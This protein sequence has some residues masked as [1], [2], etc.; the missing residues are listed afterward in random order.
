MVRVVQEVPPEI[1]GEEKGERDRSGDGEEES[2]SP[3]CP[4]EAIVI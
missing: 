4:E 1:S 3:K 2:K